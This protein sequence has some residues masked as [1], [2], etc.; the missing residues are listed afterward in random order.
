MKKTTRWVICQTHSQVA[1]SY[2]LNYFL[3][4]SPGLLQNFILWV[5]EQHQCQVTVL[6]Q[7][8]MFRSSEVS[9]FRAAP[10][11]TFDLT[12][13]LVP[14]LYVQIWVCSWSPK[15]PC[16]TVAGAEHTNTCASLSTETNHIQATMEA[17]WQQHSISC[18]KCFHT[19]LLQLLSKMSEQPKRK[20]PHC[21][22]G[23]VCSF[24][25]VGHQ[26]LELLSCKFQPEADCTL[27]AVPRPW[28]ARENRLINLL[29]FFFHATLNLRN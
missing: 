4:F 23:G 22:S 25:L 20:A 17:I 19:P 5:P 7:Q 6:K 9:N 15:R 18:L 2:D 21:V 27:S 16:R 28:G 10:Q 24:C 11:Y 29:L 26:C 14:W 3:E 1:N 8:L 12:V 13:L